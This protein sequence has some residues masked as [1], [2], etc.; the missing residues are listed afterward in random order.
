MGAPAGM[1]PLFSVLHHFKLAE[2]APCHIGQVMNEEVKQRMGGELSKEIV[3]LLLL[4][5]QRVTNLVDLSL[6]GC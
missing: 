5:S 3:W 4:Y 2:G 6:P 1:S